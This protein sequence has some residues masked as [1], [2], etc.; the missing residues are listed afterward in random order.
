MKK[1]KKLIAI[2]AVL[3]LSAVV[4]AGCNPSTEGETGLEEESGMSTPETPSVDKRE[5]TENREDEARTTEKADGKIKSYDADN[6]IITLA[7]QGGSEMAL[8]VTN[9][10]K[11]LKGTSTV[12][13][14]QLA[15]IIDSE[16][17][18]EYNSETD[19]VTSISIKG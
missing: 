3:L 4:L 6:G 8:K 10:S 13:L 18:V 15:G 5:E 16:V 12:S 2:F 9:E 17:S 1:S 19:I 7:V 11:I 14:D